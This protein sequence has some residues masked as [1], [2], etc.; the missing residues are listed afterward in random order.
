MAA[1]GQRL[2]TYLVDPRG[3]ESFITCRLIPLDKSPGVRQIGI[4][5]VPCR[6]IAKSIQ[7]VLN[8]DIIEASGSL[9]L[10]AGQEGRNPC[11]DIH[12]FQ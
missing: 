2:C 5:E 12:F 8:K 11:H 9:Q 6:L 1:V 4:G 3:I 10:C 7:S